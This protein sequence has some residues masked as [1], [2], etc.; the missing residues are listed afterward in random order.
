VV[1]EKSHHEKKTSH[2]YQT[3]S[4]PD[5][6]LSTVAATSTQ[7]KDFGV[8]VLIVSSHAGNLLSLTEPSAKNSSASAHHPDRNGNY[9][10]KLSSKKASF[11]MFDNNP[12]GHFYIFR[13]SN[14]ALLW[15]RCVLFQKQVDSMRRTYFLRA[16]LK[17]QRKSPK[18]DDGKFTW[19]LSNSSTMNFTVKA[20]ESR[21][22]RIGLTREQ[23]LR[24]LFS[25][26]AKARAASPKGLF[27]EARLSVV[28][29]QQ[30]GE[31]NCFHHSNLV[32]CS[33][34]PSRASPNICT[35]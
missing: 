7:L 34:H 35:D 23:L 2:Q 15:K 18:S 31:T 14:T 17:K 21:H 32:Y 12:P 11:G 19:R 5:L 20:P 13:C 10:L 9:W 8:S 25:A 3:A 6:W 4:A 22:P 28:A 1:L 29:W 30:A 26:S 16:W 24:K 33:W 27:L